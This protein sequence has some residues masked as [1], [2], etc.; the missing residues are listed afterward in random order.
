MLVPDILKPFHLNYYVWCPQQSQI[1]HS[2]LHSTTN[3]H[4]YEEVLEFDDKKQYDLGAV[5]GS[6]G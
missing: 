2:D 6:V 1:L 4:S 5:G 3:L